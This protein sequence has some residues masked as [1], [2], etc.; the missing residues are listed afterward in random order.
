MSTSRFLH[1]DVG[2]RDPDVTIATIKKI[3]WFIAGAALAV[4][5]IEVIW[6][7]VRAFS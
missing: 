2:H 5:W 7:F 1:P 4:L 6:G 3:L